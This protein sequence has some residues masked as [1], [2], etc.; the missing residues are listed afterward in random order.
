MDSALPSVVLVHGA[1]HGSW[2][3]ETVLP[4]LAEQGLDV[5]TV[6]LPSTGPDVAALGGLDVDPL[7]LRGGGPR[8]GPAGRRPGDDGRRQGPAA[9]ARRLG[10]LAVPVPAAGA[11]RS[12]RRGR[13]RVGLSRIGRR[14]AA[15]QRGVP[16][17]S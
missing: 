15:V 14:R 9:A 5:R 4:L 12:P 17:T 11:G 10:A 3:W 8:S 7:D 1:W 2:C 13:P 6:D 16:G